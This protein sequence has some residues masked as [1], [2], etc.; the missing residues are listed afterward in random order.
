MPKKMTPKSQ[1]KNKTLFPQYP[2]LIIFNSKN[3]RI[4][5]NVY[6]YAIYLKLLVFF[7]I[8]R[9]Y[10]IVYNYAIYLKL[11]IFFSKYITTIY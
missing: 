8:M 5:S 2:F 11:F 9:I 10:S 4:Y 6:N 7:Y 1:A 3:V